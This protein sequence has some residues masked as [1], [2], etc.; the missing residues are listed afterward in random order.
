MSAKGMRDQHIF[1]R[2]LGKADVP[3]GHR[4]VEVGRRLR[5]HLGVGGRSG[6]ERPRHARAFLA[7]DDPSV[8]RPFWGVRYNLAAGKRVDPLRRVPA[9]AAHPV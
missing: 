7:G 1:V 6:S 2:A 3:L 8:W 4:R 5:Q 9:P